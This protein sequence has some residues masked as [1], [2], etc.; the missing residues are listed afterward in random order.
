MGDY[1]IPCFSYAKELRK[2]PPHIAQMLLDELQ[3]SIDKKIIPRM[4]V[5]GGFLNFFV[6]PQALAESTLRPLVDGTYFHGLGVRAEGRVMIEYSNHNTHKEFHIGHTRNVCLGDAI[7]KIFT[8]NGYEVMPVS[9]IGDEGTHVAKCLWQIKKHTGERPRENLS[10]WYN[11]CYATANK[12]LDS[13]T[14]EQKLVYQREI[15]EILSNLESQHGSDY[16]LWQSTKADCMAE[17]SAIYTLLDVAFEQTF[18][19]SEVSK[20]SQS[21]VDEY[22][23]KGLFV[24]S[25]GAWGVNL[26]S[27]GLGFFMARKSD[28]TSLYIT[29]DL[30]LARRKFNDFHIARS[31]YVVANE[32]NFHF[33]QLF[34]VLELMGFPQAAQCH[35]LS[36]A[37]VK[38]LEGKISSR[39][40]KTYS[41]RELY[42]LLAA[43]VATHMVKYESQWTP[44]EIKDVQHKLVVSAIKYGMLSSD[45]QKEIVFDPELWTSFEGNSGPYL[46]YCYA[47]AQAILRKV[48]T[49]AEEGALNFAL[50]THPLESELLWLLY[51]FNEVVHQAGVAYKPSQISQHLYA[52]GK[53]FNRVYAE[54]PVLRAEDAEVQRN[55]LNLVRVFTRVM[56]K[57]LG[58]LGI[59]PVERM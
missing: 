26:E 34:R 36:Y 1:A 41:F 28:G 37:H 40:G 22:I 47:R 30:A 27:D 12:A 44:A 55:R 33:R 45:P 23:A 9:Y 19:E 21:I 49:A 46:L 4:E 43:E 5:A 16:Q 15:A 58:L 10:Q 11:H 57:G 42:Q 38:L 51:D 14:P 50:Y 54:L 3:G 7:T 20:E 17:F 32:Q 25:Q 35:H 24:E 29:K 18:F 48:G 56:A 8:Y 59:V 39:G 53:A 31:I 13:A 2:S 52:L 6:A